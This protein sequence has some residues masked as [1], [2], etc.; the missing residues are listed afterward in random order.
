ME[1]RARRRVAGSPGV[2]AGK[3]LTGGA[4]EVRAE[5]QIVLSP[6]MLQFIESMGLYFEQY[7]IARI[8]GRILG[9]LI[10]ADRPLSLDEIATLLQVSRASVST[11]LRLVISVDL[12]ELV[13]FP[14]D[15]RDYYRMADDPW[16]Q[17]IRAEL[18]AYPPLRRIAENALA[19][20][21]SDDAVARER[22]EEMTDFCDFVSGE[23]NGFLERWEARRAAR[24]QLQENVQSDVAVGGDASG[25]K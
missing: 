3:P 5:A 23:W 20:L 22:L 24:S 11:N 10:I 9:L 25:V 17:G 2:P 1:R 7:G 14:G 12:A 15:R 8:G 16:G 21:R 13:T 18:K 4:D 6:G 19:A